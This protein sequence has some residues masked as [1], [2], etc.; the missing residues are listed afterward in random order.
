MVFDVVLRPLVEFGVVVLL[1]TAC[2]RACLAQGDPYGGGGGG[3]YG[4]YPSSMVHPHCDLGGRRSVAKLDGAE[5]GAAD[6]RAIVEAAAYAGMPDF[7]C[8]PVGV[9]ADQDT[10]P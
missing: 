8:A 10:G 3:G 9:V 6:D 5:G 7:R 1:V 4:G 2:T